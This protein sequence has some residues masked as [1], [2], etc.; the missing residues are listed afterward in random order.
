MGIPSNATNA[1]YPAYVLAKLY[2]PIPSGSKTRE[3]YGAVIKGKITD[4]IFKRTLYKKFLLIDFIDYTKKTGI[5]Y[6]K[7]IIIENPY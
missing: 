2:I 4:E 6:T 5:N 1:K 3:T 7:L